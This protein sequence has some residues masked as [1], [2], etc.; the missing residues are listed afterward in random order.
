MRTCAHKVDLVLVNLVNQQK[1]AADVALSM[2]GPIAFQA[3]IQPLGAKGRI[4]G[5][6]HHHR[7]FEP[8]QVVAP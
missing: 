7:F 6:Q 2:V 8:H 5:D 1:V 4:I 3:V